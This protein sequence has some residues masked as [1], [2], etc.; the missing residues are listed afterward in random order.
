MHF[1]LTKLKGGRRGEAIADTNRPMMSL[2]CIAS[3]DRLSNLQKLLH[4]KEHFEVLGIYT[5]T[6]EVN[7]ILN[8]S[9]PQ[10]TNNRIQKRNGNKK[11]V[12]SIVT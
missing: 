4:D 2:Q 8:L 1:H 9:M 5:K 7:L 3:I 12:N 11:E 10:T 6:R